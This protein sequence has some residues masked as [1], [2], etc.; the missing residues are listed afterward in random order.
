ML[1][2]IFPAVHH[3]IQVEIMRQASG[4]FAVTIYD[5][6]AGERIGMWKVFEAYSDAVDYALKCAE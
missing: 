1:L 3:G 6:D 5:T 2:A 4:R